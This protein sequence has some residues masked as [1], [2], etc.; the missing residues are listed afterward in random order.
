MK[1]GGEIGKITRAL[2]LSMDHDHDE[3]NWFQY[4]QLNFL[5]EI[6]W[7]EI[8]LRLELTEYMS[9]RALRLYPICRSILI[10]CNNHKLIHCSQIAPPK[11][12]R[13]RRITIQI[14]ET[15]SDRVPRFT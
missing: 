7:K 8:E 3:I 13:S 4:H 5:A 12:R 2:S 11:K 14:N 6:R 9:V 1:I 10:D 15:E